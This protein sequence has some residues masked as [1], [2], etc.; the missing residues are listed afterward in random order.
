[1]LWG[2]GPPK[3]RAFGGRHAGPPLRTDPVCMS[4]LLNRDEEF[5]NARTLL[6]A[7]MHNL[8]P[9]RRWRALSGSAAPSGVATMVAM[10]NVALVRRSYWRVVL[11]LRYLVKAYDDV[12]FER[13]IFLEGVVVASQIDMLRV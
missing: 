6:V 9:Q 2:W 10:G 8:G 13:H 7:D 11:F 1:M 3:S 5:I 12:T 4:H